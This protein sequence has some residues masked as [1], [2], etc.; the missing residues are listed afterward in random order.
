MIPD[1]NKQKIQELA[2][3][4]LDSLEVF[5]ANSRVGFPI[6]ASIG[7][8]IAD[9]QGLTFNDYINLADDKMYS[10]KKARKSERKI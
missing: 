9:Y 2:H 6:E 4:L 1:Y 3:T 10:A 7:W 5:S 8:V